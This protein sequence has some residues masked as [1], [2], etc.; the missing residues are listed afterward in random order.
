MQLASG[1]VEVVGGVGGIKKKSSRPQ[2]ILLM[3]QQ[4]AHSQ[5]TAVHARQLTASQRAEKNMRASRK[6]AIQLFDSTMEKRLR[7]RLDEARRSLSFA[8][9]GVF[10]QGN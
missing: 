9:S 2:R 6:V 4:M 8:Q 1:T 7:M 5:E 10:F 3:E